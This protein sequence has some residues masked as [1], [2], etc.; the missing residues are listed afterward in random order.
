MLTTQ[1]QRQVII[2]GIIR[3]CGRLGHNSAYTDGRRIGGCVLANTRCW[4]CHLSNED[5]YSEILHCSYRRL[6]RKRYQMTPKKE[7]Q[8]IGHRGVWRP[9]N[10]SAAFNPPPGISIMKVVKHSN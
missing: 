8:R 6:I 5:P 9:S 4:L 1:M 2:I 7:I 10:R 3:S